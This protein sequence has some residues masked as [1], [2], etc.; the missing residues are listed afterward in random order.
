M[1]S[2]HQLRMQSIEDD[3]KQFVRYLESGN[4]ALA[5]SIIRKASHTCDRLGMNVVVTFAD[6]IRAALETADSVKELKQVVDEH[7]LK[8]P[9]C[10]FTTLKGEMSMRAHVGRK[11]A[12]NMS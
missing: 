10:A 12:T 5:N 3:K 11:H 8:C 7:S 4:N 6:L 9:Y 2:D 1:K